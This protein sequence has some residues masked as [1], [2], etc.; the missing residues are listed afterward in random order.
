LS[1]PP[2]ENCRRRLQKPLEPGRDRGRPIAGHIY[3]G[4]RFQEP[5][6]FVCWHRFAE[7]ESLDVIAALPEQEF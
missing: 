6:K 1:C 4:A 2:Y 3:D 5:L 7:Q